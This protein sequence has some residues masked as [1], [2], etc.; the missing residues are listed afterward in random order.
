MLRHLTCTKLT[1]SIPSTK[2]GSPAPPGMAG[3]QLSVFPKPNLKEKGVL[4]KHLCSGVSVSGDSIRGDRLSEAQEE[5]GR[6]ESWGAKRNTLA[7]G[8][9]GPAQIG[10]LSWGARLRAEDAAGEGGC[11]PNAECQMS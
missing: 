9:P 11:A 4:R 2:Y 5:P 3:A 6:A 1:G 7:P 10:S 8:P